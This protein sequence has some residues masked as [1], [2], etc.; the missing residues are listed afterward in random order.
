MFDF[1]RIWDRTQIDN[2]KWRACTNGEIP[3]WVADMD[4]AAPAPILDA[5]KARLEH[6]FF[7]YD[8]VSVDALKTVAEHYRNT[9]GCRVEDDWFVLIPSVMP[10]VNMGCMAAGGGIMYCTPMYMH[11]RRVGKETGLP[12]TEVP[13]QV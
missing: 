5:L 4:F 8:S 1:D 2:N 3:M 6:P 7:G 12:V 10:G 11:I 9:Y 13:M